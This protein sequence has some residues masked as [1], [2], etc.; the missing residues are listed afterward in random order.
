[1]KCNDGKE[2]TEKML[3]EEVSTTSGKELHE[4]ERSDPVVRDRR[5]K[6]VQLITP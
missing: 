3:Q 2:V 1:M 4:G 6:K 5:K